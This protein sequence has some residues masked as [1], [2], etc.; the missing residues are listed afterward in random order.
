MPYNTAD[1]WQLY[2]DDIYCTD[3]GDILEPR[4]YVSGL[5]ARC[6]TDHWAEHIDN[7]TEIMEAY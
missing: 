2:K 1:T 3:C 5:C 7:D 4:E 6:E